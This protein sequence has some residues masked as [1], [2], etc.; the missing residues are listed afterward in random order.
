MAVFGDAG[1]QEAFFAFFAKH[2]FDVSDAKKKESLISRLRID[3]PPL[4]GDGGGVGDWP[5]SVAL[6][7]RGDAEVAAAA[8]AA[9]ERSK[10][11]KPGRN[12]KKQ[13]QQ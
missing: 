4:D 2:G 6:D 11:K 13:Q 9:E 1:V 7:G 8:A 12:K 5:A 3:A 10:D